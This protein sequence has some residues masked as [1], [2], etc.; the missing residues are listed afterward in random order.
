VELI[1]SGLNYI[2][3]MVVIF[4]TNYSFSKR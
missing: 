1:H 2:F 4:M 3:D